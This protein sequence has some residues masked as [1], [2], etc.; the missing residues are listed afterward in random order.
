MER[1]TGLL[2]DLKSSRQLAELIERDC[3]SLASVLAARDRDI[4]SD[5]SRGL[6]DAPMTMNN[7]SES[8]KILWAK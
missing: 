6:D 5:R 7:V 1:I 8:Y 2:E 4:R 3:V